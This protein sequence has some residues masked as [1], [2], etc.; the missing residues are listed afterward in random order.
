MLMIASRDHHAID[1]FVRQHVFR[2][3]VVCGSKLKYFLPE[4]HVALVPAPDIANCD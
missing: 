3:F 1:I 2:V 4:H